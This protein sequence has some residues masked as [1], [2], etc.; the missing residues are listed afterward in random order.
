MLVD[1]ELAA[2]RKV[3]VAETIPVP[4]KPAPVGKLTETTP[5]RRRVAG[6]FTIKLL[7]RV[8]PW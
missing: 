3:F 8:S 5:L 6:E 7:V 2:L 4:L 1:P